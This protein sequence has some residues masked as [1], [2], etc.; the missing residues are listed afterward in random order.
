MT[1]NLAILELSLASVFWGLGF[2]ATKWGLAELSF[3]Q[4]LF[5]RYLLA[6][7]LG[8]GIYFFLNKKLRWWPN[9]DLLLGA[10]AGFIL[11][12]VMIFQTLGLHYTTAGKSGFI[13]TLYVVLVPAFEIFLAKHFHLK[14]A[15]SWSRILASCAV[16]LMSTW[17]LSGA[18][19]F[20]QINRGDWLTLISAFFSVLHILW[21]GWA[22]SKN[23][24]HWRHIQSESALDFN[25]KQSFV[26]FVL[27]GVLCLLPLETQ[28]PGGGIKIPLEPM[29]W[30]GILLTGAGASLIAFTLQ[31]RA[32]RVLSPTVSSML[33]L[34]EAPFAVIFG[35]L[36]LSETLTGLQI[37]GA[38]GILLA[39]LMTIQ[40]SG[41][42][43]QKSE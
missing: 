5:W 21:I 43:A 41:S 19:N 37:L 2:V 8:E 39:S 17:L 1:P 15:G 28:A 12:A 23:R 11:A 20:S 35:F 25:T 22:L 10:S 40:S 4:F 7:L 26:C 34:L 36:F 13:T 18:E 16:A 38:F 29:T 31:V 30:L 9:P 32:Q 3:I 24:S 6:F 42:L 27:F 14:V 33:F